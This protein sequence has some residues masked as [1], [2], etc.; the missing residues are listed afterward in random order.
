[1]EKLTSLPDWP[2]VG[3][4]SCRNHC[5]GEI[6]GR[7]ELTTTQPLRRGQVLGGSELTAR[8]AHR[9]ATAACSSEGPAVKSDAAENAK[10][11]AEAAWSCPSLLG[12]R[13]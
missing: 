12:H 9:V 4:A 3:G 6:A 11:A 8:A 5:F 13:G 1:M 7:G 10:E 2:V